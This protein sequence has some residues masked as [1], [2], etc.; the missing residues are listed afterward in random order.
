M[1]GFPVQETLTI[2]CHN[3]QGLEISATPLRLT[4]HLVVFEVYNPE[5]ILQLSEVL[6][7]FKVTRHGRLLYSGKVVVSNL[8]QVGEISVCE[9]RLQEAWWDL[10]LLPMRDLRDHRQTL[11]T[12]FTQFLR[13]WQGLYKILPEYKIAVSDIQSFLA[14]LRLWLDQVEMTAHLPRTNGERS[15]RELAHDLHTPVHGALDALFERFEIAAE[16]IERDH[17]PAHEI[18][19]QRQLHPLLLSSPFMHR[20]FTK[21]LGYAGDYEMVNMILRDPYEGSSLF[22]KLLNAYILSQNPAKAHRNRVQYLTERIREESKRLALLGRKIRILNIGCGP[23]K[24]V[25]TFLQE[26]SLAN[27]AEF[28]LLDFNEE[29]LNHTRSQAEALKMQHGRTTAFHFVKKSVYAMLKESARSQG[30]PIEYDFVYCAGLFD[31]LTDRICKELINR[32]Y[33][34][35]APCGLFVGTNVDAS[36]PIRNV[37]EYIFDWRLVYRT[38]ESLLSLAPDRMEPD[39]VFLKADSTANNLFLELRKPG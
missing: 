31:Y 14:D 15:G 36:I 26:D 4:Q 32:F 16:R 12:E 9:A 1:T 6:S 28:T 33:D 11:S 34:V 23:A 19:C 3:S 17:Q 7:E 27:H 8:I 37:M 24:E 22:G 35:L 5:I 39:H 18:F 20:I 29:T 21:P 38:R 13:Q 25:Q 30:A 2:S 10:R